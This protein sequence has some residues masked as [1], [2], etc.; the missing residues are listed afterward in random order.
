[1]NPLATLVRDMLASRR[2]IKALRRTAVAVASLRCKM[3]IKMLFIC[4]F[5]QGVLQPYYI[6]VNFW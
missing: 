3:P 2:T 4:V 5:I 6:N 1:M